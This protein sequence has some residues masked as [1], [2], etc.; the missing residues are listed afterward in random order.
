MLGYLVLENGEIFE[1]ER[2]GHNSDTACEV[3]F[4]TG[5]A[6]YIEIFTDPSY[7]GQGIVMTYPLIGN[8]GIIP[9]D[10]ESDKIWAKAVFIHEIAEFESNFRKKYTLDKFLRDNKIPG[11]ANINTRKLTKILRDFGT[12]KGYVTS[13]I[14]NIEE[15]IEKI[16]KYNVGKAVDYVTSKE[17]VSYGKTRPKQ[18]ALVDFGFK[19]NIVNSLLKRDVGVTV[20]PANTAPEI[21]LATRPDGIV[22]S[23]GPGDPEECTFEIE[24]IKRLYKTNIP[25]LGIGLG[26]QLMGIATGAKIAKLKYGHRGSNHPVKDLETNRIYITYQNHGYYILEDSLNKDIVEVSHINLND[27]T[28]EGLNYINKNIFTVQFYPDTCSGQ[29]GTTYIFDE[30]VDIVKEGK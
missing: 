28:I 10:C 19:H 9:E 15:I 20:Y 22:L 4:N 26:H 11:L 5:M 16:K 21:I 1:G 27:G 3:V 6:G 8:Y 29:E 18:V 2:I 13:N 7:A 24:T 25:I 30:F 23:N 12:M 14:S 17:K